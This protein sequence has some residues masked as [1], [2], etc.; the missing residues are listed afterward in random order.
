MTRTGREQFSEHQA[1]LNNVEFAYKVTPARLAKGDLISEFYCTM[2]P[3]P[4]HSIFVSVY[5]S[6]MNAGDTRKEFLKSDRQ[7]EL[8][9]R[10]VMF[11]LSE[12]SE[13]EEISISQFSCERKHPSVK[14]VMKRFF[15]VMVKNLV[16]SLS[17]DQE[18]GDIS[19]RKSAKLSSRASAK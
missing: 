16:K 2:L 14:S 17:S 6:I 12:D 4:L 11:L 1:S 5:Q 19:K 8:F 15:N 13:L 9:V 7:Q 10:T 18:K 3:P